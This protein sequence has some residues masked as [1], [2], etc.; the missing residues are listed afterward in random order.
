MTNQELRIT[1]NVWAIAFLAG[2]VAWPALA[3]EDG[4]RRALGIPNLPWYD[5]QDDQL[6]RVD[7]PTTREVD[8]HRLSDWEPWTWNWSWTSN[9]RGLSTNIITPLGWIAIAVLLVLIVV[10]LAWA[11]GATPW[12]SSD[13]AARSFEVG[14]SEIDRIEQLPFQVRAPVGDLLSEARRCYE[15]GRFREA[16]VYL[17]SYQ[18]VHLDRKQLI[19]LAKGKTNRQYLRELRG[20]SG[21]AALLRRTMLAF[22]DVFFGHHEIDRACFEAC[23]RDLDEF[24][25]VVATHVS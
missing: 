6:R 25:Q 10:C 22:E 3:Q 2:T 13:P 8:S 1:R 16:I 4:A 18:L 11:F 20:V 15:E 24:H 21:V 9:S 14:G 23:W 7:V 19:Q 17:F 5:P 12:Q